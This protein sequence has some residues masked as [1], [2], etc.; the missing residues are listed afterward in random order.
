MAS[1]REYFDRDFAAT[2]GSGTEWTLAPRDADWPGPGPVPDSVTVSA[3]VQTNEAAFARFVTYF[4]PREVAT[5]L[6]ALSWLVANPLRL[7]EEVHANALTT[8]SHP[9]FDPD[10]VATKDIPFS[11]R[12]FLYVDADVP[13]HVRADLIRTAKSLGLAL[14]I[15]DEA[16]RKFKS[17]REHPLAFICHDSRDKEALAGRWLVSC[18]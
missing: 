14:Q 17:D 10:G 13:P 6:W 15:R 5:E 7:V 4:V 3:R 11:G 18:R 16:Y 8:M 2:L 12:V 1:L 9:V